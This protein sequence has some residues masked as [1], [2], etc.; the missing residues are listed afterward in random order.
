MEGII[1]MTCKTRILFVFFLEDNKNYSCYKYRMINPLEEKD[2]EL[3][4]NL[5]IFREDSKFLNEIQDMLVV[6]K[7]KKKASR[8]GCRDKHM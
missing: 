4:V 3:E 7:K 2:K 1:L 8:R 5:L 6:E